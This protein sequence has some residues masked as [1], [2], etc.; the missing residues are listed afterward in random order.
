MNL[1]KQT[2]R[3]R[4]KTVFW[5]FASLWILYFIVIWW[6]A[7]HFDSVGNMITG[8]VGIWGDGALHFTMGSALA[9]R[10]LFLTQSPLLVN[11]PFRYPLAVNF[12]SAVLIRFGVPFFSAFTVP[13]FF[14]CVFFIVALF[15][16]YREY[17]NSEVVAFVSG[18]VYLLNGGFGFFYFFG[19]VANSLA[20][21]HTLFYPPTQY[22]YNTASDLQWHSIIDSMIIRQRSFQLGFPIA[23]VVLLLVMNSFKRNKSAPAL[24]T[25][26]LAAILWGLLSIVHTHSFLAVGIILGC[27]AFGSLALDRD[28]NWTRRLAMWALLPS[29]ALIV[30][31]PF[32]LRYSLI[33]GGSAMLWKPGWY[34]NTF[35][36]WISFWLMNWGLTP[37]VA[38]IGVALWIREQPSKKERL[39]MLFWF[40]P[41]ASLFAI[42]NLVQLH[43]WIWDNTKLLVWA[44]VGISGLAGFVIVR[45]YERRHRTVSILLFIVLILSGF[46]DT[47]R[48]LIPS[49]NSNQMYSAEELALGRWA[50]ENT[51]VNSIWLSAPYHYNWAFNLTGRQPVMTYDGWL[52]SH[53]YNYLQ[54]QNDVK[55]LF[56]HPEKSDLFKEY[57]I[58]YIVMGPREK[59]MMGANND[60]FAKIFTIAIKSENYTVYF[61][62]LPAP[63]PK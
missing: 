57:G 41:F 52:W 35:R 25:I 58:S 29:V 14:Y 27:W 28:A 11:A 1:E 31:A 20:P 39:R 51:P 37:I 44:S 17:F 5:V 19:D 47:Y 8:H 56:A 30:A 3:L 16:F 9:F 23:L 36:T 48:T 26:F 55:E 53:G 62:P 12:I 24:S 50:R 13:S 34:A 2:Y 42:V 60:A 38:L 61:L 63:V 59:Q 43:R 18:F 45:L 21:W 10:D 6:R 49:L 22:T 40:L 32:L 7:V 46:L 54:I 4:P 33:S 15:I